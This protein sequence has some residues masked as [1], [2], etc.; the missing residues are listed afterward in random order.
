M[1]MTHDYRISP[2][3]Q[4][5]AQEVEWA[6]SLLI[7]NSTFAFLSSRKSPVFVSAEE[8]MIEDF[9]Y[10]MIKGLQGS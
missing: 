7:S 1:L 6:E 3:N 2:E 5:S 4:N 8:M 9:G 10:G